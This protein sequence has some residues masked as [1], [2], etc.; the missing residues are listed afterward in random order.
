M[1]MFVIRNQQITRGSLLES[2]QSI[3]L[4]A[5]FHFGVIQKMHHANAVLP[6]WSYLSM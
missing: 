5:P 3:K 4:D 6:H 1:A 2:Q